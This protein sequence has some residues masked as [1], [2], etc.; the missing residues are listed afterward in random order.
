MA[1]SRM[2][3]RLGRRLASLDSPVPRHAD[4]R[5]LGKA[6]EYVERFR[7]IVSDPLNL[8]V[9]RVP[10]AGYVDDA[11]CVILHNG[12]RVP[13]RGGYYDGFSEI[14]V[15]NR[16]VHEP[17]EEY[18]FQRLVR[19]F[20]GGRPLMLELGSYWAHYSMWLKKA[21]PEASCTMVE[22]DAG[23]LS[24]G[25]ENFRR[26]GMEGTFL[27]ALVGPGA[28]EI[29]AY[30]QRERIARIDLV[31]SDIQGAEVSMLEGGRRFLSSHGATYLMV[32]THSEEIHASVARTLAAFGYRVEVSS[33]VD[34][35]TT[36]FDGFV[37]ASAPHVEPVL[38][39]FAPMGRLEIAA[40]NP[41][42]LIRYLSTVSGGEK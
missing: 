5:V 26:N 4:P 30:V 17:L 1:I 2:I 22:P 11:G 40:G 29:D 6:T 38:P 37:F 12:N 23:N 25:R 7:E 32:S 36:S 41:G 14:L 27:Q 10:E 24:V 28:F 13:L 42:E 31:H 8:L 9:D 15:I 33:P 19:R 21:C 39:G 34:S 3:G 20:A 16:G 18:C 35:H